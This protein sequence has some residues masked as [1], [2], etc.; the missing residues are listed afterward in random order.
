MCYGIYTKAG[1]FENGKPL[2]SLGHDVK[3]ADREV[4]MGF[5]K[6]KRNGDFS[7]HYREKGIGND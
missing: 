3:L 6:L 1:S 2:S 4:S 7:S 5:T